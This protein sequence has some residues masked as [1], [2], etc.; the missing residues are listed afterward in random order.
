MTYKLY[1]LDNELLAVFDSPAE[2]IRASLVYLHNG[3]KV[4]VESEPA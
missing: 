3:I 1:N 2:A 4:F